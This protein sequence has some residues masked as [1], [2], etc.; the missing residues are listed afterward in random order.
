MLTKSKEKEEKTSKNNK[1]RNIILIVAGLLLLIIILFL[2]WF[3]NRKFE[4][5]FDYNNGTKE[6]VVYVKYN[7]TINSKDVK[8]KEGANGIEYAKEVK[9]KYHNKVKIL[10]ITGV[11]EITFLNTAKEYNLDGLI[12]KDTDSESLL[13][14]ISQVLKGYTLFPDNCMY[15]EE[16]EKFKDLSD[17]EIKIIRCICEAKDRDEIAEEL[18]ITLGTLKNYISNILTKL[19]FDN[20]T[21]LTIFCLSNGYIVP[22]Q[23]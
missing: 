14:S 17:K 8:T 23:K 19:E 2:L 13:F 18:N 9:D 3:F 7:K 16:S 22:N 1:K 21:K 10:A 20:I 6:E 4:V 15:S 5:T 12:Y 11:P